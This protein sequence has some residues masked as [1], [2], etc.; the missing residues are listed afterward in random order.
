MRFK[1]FYAKPQPIPYYEH[2]HQA[3]YEQN[4]PPYVNYSLRGVK[5]EKAS[6]K[7]LKKFRDAKPVRRLMTMSEWEITS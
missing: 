3:I 7:F 4:A 2:V 6:I 5:L 1:I